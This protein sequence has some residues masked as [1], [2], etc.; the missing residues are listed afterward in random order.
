MTGETT[1]QERTIR[2]LLSKLMV[3]MELQNDECLHSAYRGRIEVVACLNGYSRFF[4]HHGC[5]YADK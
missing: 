1:W 4:K 2:W 5:N 3:T